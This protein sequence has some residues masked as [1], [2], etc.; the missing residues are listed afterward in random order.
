MVSGKFWG[1]GH[2]IGN[3]TRS[4]T[5]VGTYDVFVRKNLTR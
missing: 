2:R 3:N 5:F 1:F 4:L